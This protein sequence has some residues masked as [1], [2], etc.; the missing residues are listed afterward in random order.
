ML[1]I[2]V[3]PT[4]CNGSAVCLR[5]ASGVFHVDRGLALVVDPDA[6][7]ESAVLAAA[8]ECPTAAITVFRDGRPLA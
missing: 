1:E 2:E 6:A 5:V 3:D 7:P 8:K 4:R